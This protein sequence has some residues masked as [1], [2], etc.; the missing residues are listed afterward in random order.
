[1][2]SP[3][4]VALHADVVHVVP[5][6]PALHVQSNEFTL[7]VLLFRDSK[8]K[9][10]FLQG[11]L[12][13]SSVSLAQFAPSKPLAHLHEYLAPFAVHLAPLTH[14]ELAHGSALVSQLQ[15]KKPAAQT[16]P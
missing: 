6:Q 9:A 14:G 12:L 10:P 16:Q 8:Q 11:V 3:K 2:A 15:P 4:Y 13:H 1:M 7:I 5:V